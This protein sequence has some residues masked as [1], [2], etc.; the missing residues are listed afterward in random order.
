MT[1]PKKERKLWGCD[2]GKRFDTFREILEHRKKEHGENYLV[3]SW[4]KGEF[5]NNKEGG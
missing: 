1:V 5:S 4:S 2:C 3:C